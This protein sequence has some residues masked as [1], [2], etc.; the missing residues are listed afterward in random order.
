M[1]DGSLLST[2]LKQAISLFSGK[3]NFRRAAGYQFSLAELYETESDLFKTEDAL[4]TYDLA[5]EWY[6]GDQADAY[7]L[8]VVG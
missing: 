8:F 3:G 4:D 7:P 2:C 6:Y 1:L 5:A